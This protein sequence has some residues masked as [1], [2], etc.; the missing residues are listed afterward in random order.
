MTGGAALQDLVH[1]VDTLRATLAQPPA[2]EPP[3]VVPLPANAQRLC[4]AYDTT[5]CGAEEPTAVK[6]HRL[7]LAE[8][9]SACK[10]WQRILSQAS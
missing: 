4:G 10:V 5:R 7:G 2:P 6:V 8:M 9:T 1:E 3:K